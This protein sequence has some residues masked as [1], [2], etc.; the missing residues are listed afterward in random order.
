MATRGGGHASDTAGERLIAVIRAAIKLLDAGNDVAVAKAAASIAAVA[1]ECGAST[2]LL[3]EAIP[4]LSDLIVNAGGKGTHVRR[5]SCAALTAVMGTHESL[6]RQAISSSGCNRLIL[7]LLDMAN[8]DLDVPTK[9]NAVCTIGQIC[10]VPEGVGEVIR[11]GGIHEIL[12]AISWAGHSGDE[13]LEASI[14]DVICALATE[15]RYHLD[16]A[17]EGAIEKLAALLLRS[18]S[19][20]VEVRALMAFGMLL[21]KDHSDNQARL[22]GVHGIVSRLVKL[23]QS[24]DQDIKIIAQTLFRTLASNSTLRPGV[25]AELRAAAQVSK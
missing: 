20:E 23:T 18:S 1:S 5:N 2:E 10:Q 13:R 6:L 8:H 15:K 4:K 22:A 24:E 9:I 25:E 11:A 19:R 17:R 12:S 16:L 14:A 7:S 21:G 3:G